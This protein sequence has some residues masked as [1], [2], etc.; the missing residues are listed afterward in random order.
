MK[1]AAF[2]LKV[3]ARKEKKK[4]PGMKKTKQKACLYTYIS[5]AEEQI[6]VS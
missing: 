2:K 6:P 4:V 1:K 5:G 3:C